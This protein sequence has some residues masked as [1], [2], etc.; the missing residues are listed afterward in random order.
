MSRSNDS[1]LAVSARR[2]AT[3]A[4]CCG[5][6][7]ADTGAPARADDGGGRADTGAASAV[8]LR[9]GLDVALLDDALRVPVEVP[10][11]EVRA[12]LSGEK[13]ALTVLLDGVAKGR[14]VTVL[15][16]DA[17][18]AR[19]TRTARAA[20]GYASLS[21]AR[22]NVPGLPG[23]PLVEAEQVTSRAVCE[24][25][26][27]PVAT[28]A[29]LGTV[30][31]LGERVT[32]G[33]GRTGKVTVPGVGEVRLAVA[34]TTTTSRTAASAALDLRVTINPLRLNVASVTGRVTLAEATC[35]TPGSRAAARPGPDANGPGTPGTGPAPA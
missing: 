28:S 16:A 10:V 8:V 18:T 30:T 35:A 7:C 33:A 17:V 2:A 22:V 27:R 3:L 34:E 32:L 14:P 21:Q 13:T 25:G 11:N 9:A 23:L 31:V 19:T 24:V 29:P 5:L 6:L 12:P 26:A 1:F 15:R 4:A 20:T